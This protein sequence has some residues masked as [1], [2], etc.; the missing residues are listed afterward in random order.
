[1]EIDRLVHFLQNGAQFFLSLERR[2]KPAFRCKNVFYKPIRPFGFALDIKTGDKITAR[3]QHAPGFAER[4]CFIGKGM[5]AVHADNDIKGGI[6]HGQVAY[7][8][9]H[10][11]DVGLPGQPFFGLRKHVCAVIKAGDLRVF[12]GCPF[13][14]REHSRPD[15]NIQ[16]SPRKIIRDVRQNFPRNHIVVRPAPK[17]LDVQSAEK[18]PLRENIIIDVFGGFVSIL[19]FVCHVVPSICAAWMRPGCGC[20]LAKTNLIIAHGRGFVYCGKVFYGR[21]HETHEKSGSPQGSEPL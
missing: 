20:I 21:Q 4:F 9:L 16:Q 11:L 8:A 15:G 17:Q 7:I 13:V 10:A 6:V 1:M 2:G 14:L 12:Q 19:Y 5:E 18:V 3:L